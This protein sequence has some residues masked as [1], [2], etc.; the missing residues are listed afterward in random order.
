MR[1]EFERKALW[2]IWGRGGEAD[3]HREGTI[4][5][6]RFDNPR[7]SW[8][9][10][11][12]IVRTIKFVAYLRGKGHP[13][14]DSAERERER[15]RERA[16]RKEGWLMV[17]WKF[18]EDP[19]RSATKTIS[20]GTTLTGVV[21]FHFEAFRSNF[22]KTRFDQLDWKYRFTESRRGTNRSISLQRRRGMRKMLRELNARKPG[23]NSPYD[24]AT[25][26]HLAFQCTRGSIILLQIINDNP[27]WTSARITQLN[28]RAWSY[29]VWLEIK[30]SSCRL[31]SLLD[32]HRAARDLTRLRVNWNSRFDG[33]RANP[34]SP[35]GSG[36]E[37]RNGYLKILNHHAKY[38]NNSTCADSYGIRIPTTL[39]RTIL[40]HKSNS[41]TRSGV[42]GSR[43]HAPSHTNT[44]SY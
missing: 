15:E 27:Q 31:M 3:L 30:I 42:R 36:W 25:R 17:V 9:G 14:S 28:T 16:S 33:E 24:I 12:S 32:F 11:R 13:L 37:T 43:I 8:N 35:R 44:Y 10:Q 21:L 18:Y 19:S 1:E 4:V 40:H 23:R 2:W 6:E 20:R 22:R 34:E 39:S 7:H 38:R 26:N 5:R 29:R 41:L